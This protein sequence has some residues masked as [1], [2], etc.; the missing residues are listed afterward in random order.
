[1]TTGFRIALCDEWSA[2]SL[3]TK[4]KA[5]KQQNSAERRITTNET[6][7][8]SDIVEHEKQ[9]KPGDDSMRCGRKGT[10]LW[11]QE[12]KLNYRNIIVRDEAWV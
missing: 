12:R 1:L 6:S 10:S 11:L 4:H 5:I 2:V 8:S 7:I 3:A 9:H